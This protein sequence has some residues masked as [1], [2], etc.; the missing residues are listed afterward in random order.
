MSKTYRAYAHD[1]MLLLP[2]NPKERLPEGH[3][4]YFIDETVAEMDLD[5]ILNYYE[6]SD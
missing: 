4:A 2:I 1:Q 5:G 6:R 3:L